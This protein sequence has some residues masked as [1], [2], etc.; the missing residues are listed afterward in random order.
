MLSLACMP[1]AI[2]GLLA[3]PRRTKDMLVVTV[4]WAVFSAICCWRGSCAKP[5][6]RYSLVRAC[7]SQRRYTGSYLEAASLRSSCSGSEKVVQPAM[8]FCLFV[9]GVV[10][11]SILRNPALVEKSS[12]GFEGQ[13]STAAVKEVC[14]CCT[15]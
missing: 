7:P 10:F 11:R 13:F 15:R 5:F 14:F 12:W 2:G 1:F 9:S 6:F 4:L 3:F 8:T